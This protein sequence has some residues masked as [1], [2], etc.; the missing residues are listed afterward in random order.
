MAKRSSKGK[1]RVVTVCGKRRRLCF[2]K[3]GIR[4]NTKA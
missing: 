1:C 3:S 4:S 2:G